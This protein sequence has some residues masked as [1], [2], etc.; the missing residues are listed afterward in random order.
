MRLRSDSQL[1]PR[2]TVSVQQSERSTLQQP[3]EYF[4][5]LSVFKKDFPDREV[6]VLAGRP[7]YYKRKKENEKSVTKSTTVYDGEVELSADAPD[8]MYAM[9]SQAALPSQQAAFS[10]SD[11]PFFRPTYGAA[12]AT[13][14]IS[15]GDDS[16]PPLQ[17]QTVR[18]PSAP[19]A[20]IQ[21]GL[22]DS[23]DEDQAFGPPLGSGC[24]TVLASAKHKP[25]PIAKEKAKAK[26]KPKADSSAPAT[27]RGRGRG[28]GGKVA[29]DNLVS[30]RGIPVSAAPS[31]GME[32]PDQA[33]LEHFETQMKAF[34]ST[35]LSEIGGAEPVLVASLKSKSK[36]L[37]QFANSVKLKVKSLQRRKD[38]AHH[39]CEQ[40]DA[41]S[42]EALAME[43]LL[44]GLMN[45][46]GDDTVL[47]DQ[48]VEFRDTREWKFAASL[49]KRALRTTCL[50]QL[51]FGDWD[52]SISLTIEKFSAVLCPHKV[53]PKR[54]IEATEGLRDTASNSIHSDGGL[55]AVIVSVSQGK[56]LLKQSRD[57][58]EKGQSEITFLDGV[59][60]VKDELL[61]ICSKHEAGEKIDAASCIT[62]AAE[63]LQLVHENMA[64]ANSEAAKG[65]IEEAK[66]ALS[67]CA[68]SYSYSYLANT[69]CPW[70]T[71]SA[72]SFKGDSAVAPLP[73]LHTKELS[74]MLGS[75]KQYWTAD[76]LKFL[77]AASALQTQMTGLFSLLSGGSESKPV[78][79]HQALKC[80]KEFEEF[81]ASQAWFLPKSDEK[82]MESLQGMSELLALVG[83]Q[84]MQREVHTH[85]V[86][87]AK[88]MAKARSSKNME[89]ATSDA[90]S[91]DK[92][93]LLVKP[94]NVILRV[95]QRP[96]VVKEGW[97]LLHLAGSI[98]GS[99]SQADSSFE[100]VFGM[101][102]AFVDIVERIVKR[103]AELVEHRNQLYT[104]EILK[105]TKGTYEM[106]EK[107]PVFS[108]EDLNP[109]MTAFSPMEKQL[110]SFCDK[111]EQLMAAIQKDAEEFFCAAADVCGA[112]KASWL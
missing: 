54:I 10:L 102:R 85:K 81:M 17:D 13:P 42:E 52:G 34:R 111:A 94:A 63:C 71:A 61:E 6:N 15:F 104:Q 98:H 49:L 36:E 82:V 112:V 51:K 39:I 48:I 99:L 18:A 24:Y 110:L 68:K 70:F 57:L 40:L 25:A 80:G 107:L 53:P 23:S 88:L 73:P 96:E 109:F 87:L 8:R 32:T 103:S 35:M 72:S 59:V 29:V 47:I 97:S 58:A 30:G 79:A 44:K 5:E 69:A 90:D 22:E 93:K 60:K 4:V 12:S 67:G 38:K 95:L 83:G 43:S 100:M 37:S 28:R 3:K 7:G 86:R 14:A 9:S 92:V 50:S 21:D 78:D 84:S 65:L 55:A 74:E 56:A 101:D 75:K 46:S 2:T 66:G 45:F 77:K 19:A 33:L 27:G 16:N 76:A 20:P 108:T 64:K 41:F 106:T 1:G 91:R 105:V 11:L 31:A 89:A 62:K 26:A